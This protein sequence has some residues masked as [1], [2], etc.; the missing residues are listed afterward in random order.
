MCRRA[1]PDFV[2]LRSAAALTNGTTTNPLDATDTP[3]TTVTTVN[4]ACPALLAAEA[5]TQKA[6]DAALY[7]SANLNTLTS[8]QNKALDA[9]VAASAALCHGETRDH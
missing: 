7:G 8:R 9:Y 3:A 6:S 5:S 4:P 1:G 2:D